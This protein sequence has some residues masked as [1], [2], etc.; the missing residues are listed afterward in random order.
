LYNVQGPIYSATPL[1]YANG[2]IVP[3]EHVGFTA[4]TQG[5]NYGTGV[6]EGIRAYWD[7]TTGN[8]NIIRLREHWERFATSCR[9]L[10]LEVEESIDHLIATTVKLLQE[11]RYRGDVYI[12][13]IAHKLQLLPGT[14]FG[15]K[16]KGISTALTIYVVP[17]PSSG[18]PTAIRCA[19]SSWR[20]IPDSSIPARAKITGSYVNVA[21]A[22][23]EAQTAGYDDAILLNVRGTVAEASTANV[24]AVQKGQLHTPYAS[25]DILEGITR[26]C[27]A[28]I[29]E[30]NRIPFVERDIARSELYSSEEVFLTGTG[31]EVVPVVEIDGRVI[32]CGIAGPLTTALAQKYGAAVRGEDTAYSHWITP[33]SIPK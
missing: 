29:A 12:R 28:E 3:L 23:D 25:A 21:L 19:V 6:F 17:M 32:G 4:A 11:N 2:A 26:R 10:R 31:C 8:L 30:R 18:I 7:E 24:F 16:L 33:A 20:R 9:F 13:P 14:G 22:V 27:V 1:A 15:V 5:L